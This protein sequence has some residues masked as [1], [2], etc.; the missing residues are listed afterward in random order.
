MR[1]AIISDIHGNIEALEAVLRDAEAQKADEL[2]CLGDLIGYGADPNECIE[3]VRPAASVVIAG[4][5]DWAA[6]GK[7]GL[8]YFNAA[9]KRAAEWTESVLTAENR[10]YVE[11]LPL[12]ATVGDDVMLVHSSPSRPEEWMYVFHPGQAAR[13]FSAF[14]QPFCFIGHTHQPAVFT[15][16]GGFHLGGALDRFRMGVGTRYMVN[17]GSV[18]Q[19][20]DGN[21]KAAY[22]LFDTEKLTVSIRRVEYDVARS[23]MKIVRNKLPRSLAERLPLGL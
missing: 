13:D 10:R 14:E 8:E 23:S 3:A 12:T 21:P 9:A 7:L 15:D 11:R 19:P 4:N 1:Y 2:L 6:V 5:H 16:N 18:G 22:C 17:V 20:R